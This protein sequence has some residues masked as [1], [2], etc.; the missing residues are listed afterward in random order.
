MSE[1]EHR[2]SATERELLGVVYGYEASYHLVYGRT[3][4]FLTDHEP[5]VTLVTL[6][7]PMGR[8]GRLLHRLVDVDYK[9]IY[10]KGKDN[11]LADFMSRAECYESKEA[12]AM[13]TCI[14]SKVDWEREQ[15]KDINLVQV[16]E[17]IT[18]DAEDK[19]WLKIKDC[20]RWVHEK[21]NLFIFNSILKHGQGCIVVPEHL[22]LELLRWHH[23]SLSEKN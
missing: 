2:Y 22:K 6:K 19:V 12:Q 23:D 11:Y 21:K 10:I 15:N 13:F 7:N 18:M 17:C 14:Q 5:L 20:A 8:L 1:V 9:I 16:K 3:I 4:I